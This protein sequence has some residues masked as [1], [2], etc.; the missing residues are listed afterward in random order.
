MGGPRGAQNNSLMTVQHIARTV[1]LGRG[2]Q[3]G[4]IIAALRLGIGKGRDD[5]AANDA[6]NQVGR[7]GMA[8]IFQEA[9]AD[10]HGA[11]IG[12]DDQ[13]LAA[14]FHDD[15]VFNGRATQAAQI[16]GERS[17]KDAELFG[18]GLPIVCTPA[19]GRLHRSATGVEAVL[20]LQEAGEGIA[21]H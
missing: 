16:F 10:D 5:F 12:L 2:L 3:V 11:Q 6:A 4:Q 9:A 13:R 21:Q 19:A 20:I 18:E 7:A 8:G 17:A 15:H 1:L 14:L